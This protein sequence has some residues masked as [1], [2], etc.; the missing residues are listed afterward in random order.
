MATL[1]RMMESASALRSPRGEASEAAA[2]LL[3]AMGPAAANPMVHARA[4]A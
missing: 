4:P 3:A 1:A 2:L